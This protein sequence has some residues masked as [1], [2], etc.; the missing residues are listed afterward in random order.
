MRWWEQQIGGVTR[1]RVIALLR[2]GVST[3]EELAG[4]LKVTDNAVRAQLQTL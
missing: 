1:G 2:R 4:A 3:V